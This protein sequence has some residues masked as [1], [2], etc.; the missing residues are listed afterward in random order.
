MAFFSRPINHGSSQ[1]A[2]F[3]LLILLKTMLPITW[4]YECFLSKDFTEALAITYP[5]PQ[6]QCQ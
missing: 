3:W 6:H 4:A 5:L 1:K 2:W